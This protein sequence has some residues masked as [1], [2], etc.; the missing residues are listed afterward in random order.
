MPI[1]DAYKTLELAYGASMEE[2]KQGYKDLVRVWHPDRF[3]QD[4]RLKKK[5]EEKLK[6]I[7]VAYGELKAFFSYRARTIPEPA[8]PQLPTSWGRHILEI[9]GG[10][11]RLGRTVYQGVRQGL[12]RIE[13]KRMVHVLFDP[14]DHDVTGSDGPLRTKPHAGNPQTDGEAGADPA[15]LD[16]RSV[17][18][19]VARERGSRPRRGGGP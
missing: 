17:F 9:G 10:A 8:S 3:A 5:A 6:E 15:D 1:R 16:F 2:V 12:T 11:A 18:D 19:Q 4:P 7:N 13:W 14:K